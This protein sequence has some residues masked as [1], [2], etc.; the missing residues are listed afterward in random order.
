MTEEPLFKYMRGGSKKLYTATEV[1]SI[2]RKDP[3]SIL[4]WGI[5]E[6]E[7]MYKF[8]GSD[9]LFTYD[10]MKDVI[11]KDPKSILTVYQ[12]RS[13]KKPYP[14]MRGISGLAIE[15]KFG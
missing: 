13:Q 7:P 6:K 5:V 2:L 10:E 3:D 15:Q 11:H 9:S 4:F 1:R 12:S 8:V 14:V